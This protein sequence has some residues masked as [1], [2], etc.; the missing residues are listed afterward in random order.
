MLINESA[1]ACA[2]IILV[3]EHAVV[4]GHPAIAI[5]VSSLRAKATITQTNQPFKIVAKD[6]KRTYDFTEQA[7][8]AVQRL[9][10]LVLDYLNTPP[11]NVTITLQ[12][13]IP[14]ASG[15]GSGASISTALARALSVATQKNLPTAMLSDL[16][17]EVE[18]IHHG[19]PSGIDNTVIAYEQPIYFKRGEAIQTISI[20]KSFHI[21]IANTGK[22]ALT[23]ESVGDVRKQYEKHPAKTTEIL[24][25][26]GVLVANS[27]R[28]IE[29]GDIKKLG[30][31]MT[32]NHRYLQELTVSS[33]ELDLL[34][35]VAIQNGAD[36]AK[37]SGG[38]R[39][40]NMIALVEPQLKTTVATALTNAG[41]VQVFNTKVSAG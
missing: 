5:P 6:L 28:A 26:I 15:L 40:G 7:D 9:T 3:G 12:S 2:K 39:G 10:K 19:T 35:D 22:V 1:S 33:P 24:D 23:H 14:I 30:E 38:G 37:L 31:R 20:K 8:S 21:L 25:K 41:A 18:K 4:Y 17:Y 36:G 16:V 32:D 27:Q 29:L 11:P 13:D 34:V